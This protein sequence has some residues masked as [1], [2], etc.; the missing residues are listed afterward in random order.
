MYIYIYDIIYIHVSILPNVFDWG[1]K[2]G[3][4]V[5]QAVGF[6]DHLKQTDRFAGDSHPNTE[7]LLVPTHGG[8]PQT[9]DLL[10]YKP[11]EYDISPTKIMV[12][13]RYNMI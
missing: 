8:A 13:G 4:L 7:A 12:Y 1:S 3:P 5:H 2:H 6:I 11:H 9:L 10:V